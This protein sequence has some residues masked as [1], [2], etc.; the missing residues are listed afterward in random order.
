MRRCTGKS[1]VPVSLVCRPFSDRL[2]TRGALRSFRQPSVSQRF[3]RDF[4]HSIFR[5]IADVERPALLAK[6]VLNGRLGRESPRHETH[7]SGAVCR[8]GT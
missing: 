7:R 5:V 2:I 4:A 3:N 1:D 8:G 6:V